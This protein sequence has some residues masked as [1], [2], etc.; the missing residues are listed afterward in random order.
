MFGP[1]YYYESLFGLTI[2]SAAGIAWIAGWPI[3]PRERYRQRGSWYPWRGRGIVV[4]L[5]ILVVGN[6]FFY[7]P[8]RIASMR[9]LYGISRSQL[10]PF[11]TAEVRELTPALV[12]VHT[13]EWR[14]YGT[15]LELSN[16]RL[17]APF[18]FI[19]SR[20]PRSNAKIAT[21]FPERQVFHYYPENPGELVPYDR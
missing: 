4:L 10:A 11:Q 7:A 13:D 2:V 16:P 21:A 19:W 1:R 17:D 6:I 9:G 8:T 18:I 3:D 14:Q 12:I 15:L 20:G 5:A